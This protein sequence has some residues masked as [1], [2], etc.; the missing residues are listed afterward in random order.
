MEPSSRLITRQP[1][2]GDT[3]PNGNISTDLE[4][5][6]YGDIVG[7]RCAQDLGR[8]EEAAMGHPQFQ[9]QVNTTLDTLM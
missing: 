1:E 4:Q 5:M 2:N 9:A 7:L 8:A 6:G 3:S